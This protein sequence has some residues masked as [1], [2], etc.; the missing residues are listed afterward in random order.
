[1][2]ISTESSNR[3]KTAIVLPITISTTVVSM[4][5]W[6]SGSALIVPQL[7]VWSR[8]GRSVTAS[9]TVTRSLGPTVPGWAIGHERGAG[10]GGGVG[11]D[12]R[13]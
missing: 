2:Y 11:A 13:S 9:V 3:M 8:R 12:L 7:I 1:M 6:N 4:P 5:L 10:R